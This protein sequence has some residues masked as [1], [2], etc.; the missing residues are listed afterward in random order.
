MSDSSWYEEPQYP[1]NEENE[2]VAVDATGVGRN[3]FGRISPFA[4]K[5]ER[6]MQRADRSKAIDEGL[7]IAA[8]SDRR[9][10]E[11]ESIPVVQY[12]RSE[13]LASYEGLNAIPTV[14]EGMVASAWAG[15]AR[16]LAGAADRK[17]VV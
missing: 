3:A 6:S 7:A 2:I 5:S 13:R 1:D 16:N 14:A 15:T 12:D 4:S 17:S 9:M 11:P 8:E 10:N